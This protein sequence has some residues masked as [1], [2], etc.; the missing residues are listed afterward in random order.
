MGTRNARHC[1]YG[2]NG[3]VVCTLHFSP[4]SA[5]NRRQRE[6]P[7]HRFLSNLSTGS[8]ITLLILPVNNKLV[9][10]LSR[11]LCTKITTRTQNCVNGV[12]DMRSKRLSLCLLL[13]QVFGDLFMVALC[14]TADHYI[15]MLWFVLSSFF[16]FFF[17]A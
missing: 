4:I 2:V 12:I 11:L 13:A 15:F 3:G 8:P 6:R 10:R 7:Q 5:T 14:N 16:F 1:T 9:A 17:L